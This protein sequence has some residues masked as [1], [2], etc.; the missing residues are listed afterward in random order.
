MYI[1]FNFIVCII[2]D[3]LDLFD[4]FM[5]NRMIFSV[6]VTS[7]DWT[8]ASYVINKKLQPYEDFEVPK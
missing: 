7:A 5:I 8:R 3:A 6:H 1:I 4:Y 2:M